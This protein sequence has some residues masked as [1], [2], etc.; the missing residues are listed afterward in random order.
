MTK[1]DFD[2]I[3]IESFKHEYK[4]TFFK[5]KKPINCT[6]IEYCTGLM[7]SFTR[8]N[9]E[10]H[11]TDRTQCIITK[12][13][14]DEIRAQIKSDEAEVG[15]ADEDETDEDNETAWSKEVAFYGSIGKVSFPFKNDIQ[16][17]I[18][19]FS[20]KLTAEM[21]EYLWQAL[22]PYLQSIIDKGKRKLLKSGSETLPPQQN[23]FVIIETITLEEIKHEENSFWKG[24]PMD[25]V[26]NHFAILSTRKSKNGDVFLK[27]DQ[28]ISF[29]K[30]GFLNDTTQRKQI[31]NCGRGEKGLVIKRF[32]EFYDLAVS[33]YG[34]PSKTDK[35]I[36][37]FTD[38][39]SNWDENTIKPFF[40]SNK[41][42]ENW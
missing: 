19:E 28:L 6:P 25:K 37:L 32:Y 42:K 38:C 35:F 34:F 23:E 41:T 5:D 10:T 11:L 20:G 29:L 7:E 33:Q 26:V 22:H 4:K 18:P 15:Y 1:Y 8:L 24:M 40:K 17:N 36:K 13:N 9:A 3:I 27:M 31:I 14:G 30:K 39:F 2:L 16:I 21:M 12:P